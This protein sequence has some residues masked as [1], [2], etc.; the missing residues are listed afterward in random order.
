MQ[1]TKKFECPAQV[2]LKEIIYFM[3]YMVIFKW[4]TMVVRIFN[5]YSISTINKVIVIPF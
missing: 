2:I 5:I 1:D 4:F 3:D